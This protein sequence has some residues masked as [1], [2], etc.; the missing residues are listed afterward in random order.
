MSCPKMEQKFCFLLWLWVKKLPTMYLFWPT[1]RDNQFL[2]IFSG[3]RRRGER[4][5][6][7]EGEGTPY[8]PPPSYEYVL[9]NTPIGYLNLVR[10]FFSCAH[11]IFSRNLYVISLQLYFLLFLF[12]SSLSSLCLSILSYL[13]FSFLNLPYFLITRHTLISSSSSW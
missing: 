4:S 6:R 2:C 13:L 3:H 5:R 11:F 9:S 8:D 10:F 1:F 7:G 12:F